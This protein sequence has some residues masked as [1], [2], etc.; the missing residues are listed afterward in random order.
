M[1]HISGPNPIHHVMLGVDVKGSSHPA[2]DDSL[3]PQLRAAHTELVAEALRR[4]GVGPDDYELRSRGDGGRYD[5]RPGISPVPVV[6]AVTVELG[7]L[8]RRHNKRSSEALGL[9]LRLVVHG[10][11]L[12]PT[13]DGTDADGADVNL[14]HG[15]LD[16]EELRSALADGS[17]SYALAVSESIWHGAVRHGHGELDPNDFTPYRLTVKGASAV[18]VWLTPAV[19]GTGRVREESAARKDPGNPPASD[20]RDPAPSG[21]MTFH[22]DVRARNVIGR[23]HVSYR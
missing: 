12:L 2:R 19:G 20:R 11:Y 14:L 4:Q 8:L 18:P 13:A 9:G 1:P 22:G 16:A 7:R 5:F 6:E 17:G 21:G 15:L 3:L 23:D 10:G